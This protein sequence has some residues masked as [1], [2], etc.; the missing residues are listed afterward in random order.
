MA[1]L[2]KPGEYKEPWFFDLVQ[3][4]G[5][6]GNSTFTSVSYGLAWLASGEVD[7]GSSTYLPRERK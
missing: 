5:L 1:S 6:W 2:I 7:E 3:R 4:V